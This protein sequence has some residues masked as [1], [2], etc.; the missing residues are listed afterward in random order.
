[1][2]AGIHLPLPGTGRMRAE[3]KGYAWVPAEPGPIQE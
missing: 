3:R 1:M 2:V